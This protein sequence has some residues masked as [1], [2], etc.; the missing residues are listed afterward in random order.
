MAREDDEYQ[1]LVTLRH[2][3]NDDKKFLKMYLRYKFYRSLRFRVPTPRIIF[4]LENYNDIEFVHKFRFSQEE[5]Q[6]LHELIRFPPNFRTR[7]RITISSFE[8]FCITIR[9][10][11]SG[12][13]WVEL[14]Y[15]FGRSQEVL[16]TIF[17]QVISWLFDRYKHIIYFDDR[18]IT[19]Y[20]SIAARKI[21]SKSGVPL[22]R[23]IGFVDGH[24]QK[25]S[26]P[27]RYQKKTYTGLRKTHSLKY[28]AVNMP[29]GIIVS[30]MGGFGGSIH[31]AA[32]MRKSKFIAKMKQHCEG[33]YVYGD[34]A[35]ALSSA[36]M[37][38]HKKAQLSVEESTFNDRMK[39]VR[40]TVEWVFKDIRRNWRFLQPK[41]SMKLH[42]SPVAK[43]FIIGGFLTNCLTCFR[44]N[45][46]SEYFRF[47]P[48]SIQEYLDIDPANQATYD[49]LVEDDEDDPEFYYSEDERTT[50]ELEDYQ[51]QTSTDSEDA[52]D[53][54][55]PVTD[56][57]A[58]E[59]ETED[60]D[61]NGEESDGE[62]HEEDE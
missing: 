39:R 4:S 46:C 30:F 43:V 18:I 9:R 8:A 42:Q 34:S 24:I 53:F 31:D 49:A 20:K 55:D 51:S 54:D 56:D 25:I 33:L 57:D 14:M 2:I 50:S 35:Y 62:E 16:S 32:L 17:L 11:T 23:L 60:D 26:K 7:Q 38:P 3:V 59:Q 36:T 1:L 52:D 12:H 10:L 40:I 37:K 41:N 48:P 19:R 45:Q 13:R 28:Q 58:Q 21:Y 47:S 27:V 15:D 6:I 44:G 22:P 5:I 29:N 61:E